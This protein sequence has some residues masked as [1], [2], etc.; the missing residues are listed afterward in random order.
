MYVYVWLLIHLNNSHLVN[1]FCTSKCMEKS[2]LKI[3][4]ACM[5]F[6]LATLQDQITIREKRAYNT[7]LMM[8]DDCWLVVRSKDLRPEAKNF[9]IF[10]VHT[11]S[12]LHLF[13]STALN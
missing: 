6:V 7:L 5:L 10:F 12:A 11:V 1:F 9:K 8:N 3:V 2:I 13:C 4:S